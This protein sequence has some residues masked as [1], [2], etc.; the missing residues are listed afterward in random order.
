MNA[1]PFSRAV[2]VHRALCQGAETVG[3]IR[4]LLGGDAYT[5]GIVRHALRQ[6]LNF[7][8]VRCDGSAVGR[9]AVVD[10]AW[11][12][13]KGGSSLHHDFRVPLLAKVWTGRPE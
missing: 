3:E 1:A 7:G 12:P 2:A 6:L 4:A 9:W 5:T 10:R 8:V 11:R 13:V